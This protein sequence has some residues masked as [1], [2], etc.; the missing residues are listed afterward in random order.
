[1]G[2][3]RIVIGEPYPEVLGLLERV[4]RQLGYQPLR[5]RRGMH[6]DPPEA[7]ALLLE[8]SYELGRDLIA[9]LR[10]RNPGL[11]VVYLDKPFSLDRLRARLD[12]AVAS[13]ETGRILVSVKRR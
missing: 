10:R 13:R 3:P 7:D 11:R 5:L 4:V 6:G 9:A 8:R 12:Q 1:M 2:Q